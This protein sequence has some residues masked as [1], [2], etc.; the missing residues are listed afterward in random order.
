LTASYRFGDWTLC[1]AS[2]YQS[3]RGTVD[4]GALPLIVRSFLPATLARSL[5]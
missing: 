4:W 2:S 3:V 1:R 5:C